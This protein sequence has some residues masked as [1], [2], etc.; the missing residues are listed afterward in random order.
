VHCPLQSPPCVVEVEDVEILCLIDPNSQSAF[1][2]FIPL[3][4]ILI[5]LVL[6][7]M[8]VLQ[9]TFRFMRTVREKGEYFLNL[10]LCLKE[11]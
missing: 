9:K 5:Q 1:P 10:G 4:L 3:S 11:Q 6:L 8:A 7:L 2:L